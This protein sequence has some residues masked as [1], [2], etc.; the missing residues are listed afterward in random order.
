MDRLGRKPSPDSGEV[1]RTG[2]N[3]LC[4]QFVGQIDQ[5]RGGALRKDDP[6]HLTD[7]GVPCPEISKQGNDWRIHTQSTCSQ[8]Q[9]T[10]GR[11]VSQPFSGPGKLFRGIGVVEREEVFIIFANVVLAQLLDVDLTKKPNDLENAGVQ[12]SFDGW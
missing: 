11:A 2:K 10:S 1:Y 12:L 9:N 6:F 5:H 7:V 3:R 8:M 4:R